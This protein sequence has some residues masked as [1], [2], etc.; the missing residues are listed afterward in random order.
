MVDKYVTNKDIGDAL[1]IR[2]GKLRVNVDD[3]TV[4]IVNNELTAIGGGIRKGDLNDNLILEVE[5][6]DG[7][8]VEIDLSKLRNTDDYVVDG[9]VKPNYILEL[10]RRSGA[11]VSIDIGNLKGEKGAKGDKGDT[12]P[13]GPAGPAGESGKDG[14]DGTPGTGYVVDKFRLVTVDVDYTTQAADFDGATVIRANKN[15]NQVITITKPPANIE[16]QFIG[17]CIFVRKTNGEPGTFTNLNAGPGVTFSPDD[18]NPLRR[19]GN[20]AGF[21]YIGNGLYDTGGELP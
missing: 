2:G 14:K 4:K 7:S 1:Y 15:G 17:C 13:A 16:E 18:V 19:I 11:K 6:K 8:I 9:E 21:M 12:G 3:R 10:L 5:N 20:Y